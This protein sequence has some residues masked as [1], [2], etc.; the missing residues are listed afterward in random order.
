[1][2]TVVGRRAV[3]E[4][5]RGGRKVTKIFAAHH[6]DLGP[7]VEIARKKKVPLVQVERHVL[8]SY[9]KNHQGVVAIISPKEYA[10]FEDLTFFDRSFFIV[11]DRIKDPRNLGAIIRSCEFFG[12]DAVIIPARRSAP[13][14]ETVW[15][16]SAGALEHVEVVRVTNLSTTL[17]RLKENK[18]WIIGADMK[19]TPCFEKNLQGPVA[20]VLGEEHSGIRK[21]LRQQCDLLVSIPGKGRIESLNVSTAAGI[22]MY[23]IRRQRA[24]SPKTI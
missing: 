20:L 8:D 19:G 7:I 2:D 13:L 21:I 23:E 22:L 17:K 15:K 1:M 18:V 10:K 3:M 16:T 4:V 24:H 5:L 14:T 6:A 12:V 9:G 11:L